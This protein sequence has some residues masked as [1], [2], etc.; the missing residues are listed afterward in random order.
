LAS[1]YKEA[2]VFSQIQWHLGVSHPRITLKIVRHPLPS[3]LLAEFLVLASAAI[4]VLFALSFR[5]CYGLY[6]IFT[7]RSGTS[8]VLHDECAILWGGHVELSEE[9][10]PL[11][12]NPHFQVE[13]GWHWKSVEHWSLNGKTILGF[14][15]FRIVIPLS[16]AGNRFET[17]VLMPFWIYWAVPAVVSIWIAR[18]NRHRLRHGYCPTCGY[19]LRATPNRCPECGAIPKTATTRV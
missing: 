8:V 6:D 12:P 17:A 9:Q 13:T 16:P 14:R 4:F 10:T 18:R 3:T 11:P 2:R 7:T 19:D 5:R 15:F 1:G